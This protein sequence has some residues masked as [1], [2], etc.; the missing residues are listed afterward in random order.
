L[1][2]DRTHRTWF[3]WTATAFL[4]AAAAFCLYSRSSLN[5]PSG[6]TIPGIAFGVIGYGLMWYGF[7]LW[8]RKKFPSRH[9]ILS[10]VPLRRLGR[11]QTWMKGHLWLGLLSYPLILFHGGGLRFGN[12]L[13]WLLMWIFTLVTVTGV[14]GAVLQ[15]FMPRLM[16]E[17]VPM[18]SIYNNINAVLAKRMKEAEELLEPFPS[19][20]NQDRLPAGGSGRAGTLTAVAPAITGVEAC[21]A[22]LRRKYDATIKPYLAKRNAYLH[23]LNSVRTSE[24][25]FAELR[26]GM[27]EPILRIVNELEEICREKRDLDRQ[28]TL[29]WIL[30]GW[31]L[32]HIPLS[33]LLIVLGAIHAVMALHY[34]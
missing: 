26:L 34:L 23:E 14:L 28:T 18:E 20:E 19:G 22:E 5:G 30:H 24:E 31:L 12:G 29:H 32:V 17:H 15:H 11:V 6:S 27:P 9:P 1:R 33:A 25:V 16:T 4:L 10:K 2:L 8:A 7:L 13:T 3:I 21:G